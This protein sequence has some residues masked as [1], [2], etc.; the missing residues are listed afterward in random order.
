MKLIEPRNLKGFRDY[1]PKDQIPRAAMLEKIKKVFERF[2]FEPLETPA[3]E[4]E[5]ILAGK[6]GT[7]G[8]T[9]M[10]R[11]KDQGKRDVALRY[12]LTV[13]LARVVAQY[14]NELPRPFK[15]YQIAPVWR[16][17][18]TQ[19]GRY[20]EFYQCDVD[21]VGASVG[22]PDAECI[23]ITEQILLEL[24][25][26]KFKVKIN[27]RKILNAIMLTAKV[28][29]E[30]IIDAI[31]AIDK[32]EK[33]GAKAVAA[34]LLEKIDMKE[35][36]AEGL[37]RL[38]STKVP[39]IGTLRTFMSKYIL[40]QPQG[41]E[42]F[43]ELNKVFVALKEMG[44]KNV[45]IDLALARGLDYYTSTIFETVVMESTES[46]SFGSVAG[47]GRYDKLINLFTGRDVPAVGISIGVD[48]LFAAMQELGLVQK[49]NVVDVL[50]LNMDNQFEQE[51]L[52]VVSELRGA[53]INSEVYYE[54]GD[55]KKQFAFAEAK[56]IPYALLYGEEEAK[57]KSVTVRNL[58]TRKQKTMKRVGFIKALQ[59][60]L[61]AKTKN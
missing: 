46:R 52:Q 57:K 22:I 21:V 37:I 2:G 28:P 45:E 50:V 39:D 17:E 61:L 7:E 6:Y 31:R 12:D 8:E 9:M 38:A 18:N 40:Q 20:R 44:I 1:L 43:D 34:E 26:K 19:K 53:G 42:G 59:K 49:N 15:R 56:N 16:A 35:N 47:G 29:P 11:F 13:P 58:K 54:A 10:Y 60:L 55:L 27:N 33:I 3:L 4:Y 32:I 48:R 25:I 5:D 41:K 14:Q 36:E 24:G 30:K 23:A 51:Y